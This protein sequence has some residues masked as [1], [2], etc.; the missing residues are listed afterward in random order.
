MSPQYTELWKLYSRCL[1]IRSVSYI[2][3]VQ[4]KKVPKH[5]HCHQHQRLPQY[6]QPWS[7]LQDGYTSTK[8]PKGEYGEA[9]RHGDRYIQCISGLTRSTD[10]AVP[11][12]F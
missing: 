9:R 6:T 5:F 7:D 11:G 3:E 4:G 8:L 1:H 12:K 2:L 10:E